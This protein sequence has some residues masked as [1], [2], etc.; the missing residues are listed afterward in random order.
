MVWVRCL[1]DAVYFILRNELFVLS[2]Q[3]WQLYY[4]WGPSL[5]LILAEYCRVLVYG[6]LAAKCSADAMHSAWRHSWFSKQ[7]GPVLHSNVGWDNSFLFSDF[8]SCS[9]V[10]PSYVHLGQDLFLPYTSP[11]PCMIVILPFGAVPLGQWTVLLLIM[12]ERKKWSYPC[13]RPWR[14]IG[15]WDAEDPTLSRQSAHRWQSGCQP[16]VPATLYPQKY[17]LLF[18]SVGGVW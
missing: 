2:Q 1:G 9:L 14:P 4:N 12:K 13:N 3:C 18:I 16:Y 11:V 5:L 8:P 17:L 6:R 15:L 10:P 7:V